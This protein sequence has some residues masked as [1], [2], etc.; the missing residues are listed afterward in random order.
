MSDEFNPRANVRK[1]PGRGGNAEYLD[2][3]DRIAWFRHDWPEGQIDTTHITLTDQIAVFRCMAVK[4]TDGGEAHGF[5]TGHGSETPGDFKDYIEKAETKAIGRALAALGYGT[6]FLPD[7][8]ERIADAPIEFAS[9]RG[10]RLANQDNGLA[11]RASDGQTVTG[12][13]LK[14]IRVIAREAG[15]D[16][17]AVRADVLESFG[18]AVEELGRQE[19]SEYIERLQA[20]SHNSQVADDAPTTRSEPPQRTE[21][22][23][24]TESPEMDLGDAIL[25]GFFTSIEHAKTEKQLDAIGTEIK[26]SRLTP[27]EREQL[28]DPFARKLAAFQAT[29]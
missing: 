24:E 6:Q 14:F 15:L 27:A 18:C 11:P 28:R 9:T 7:D 22:P 13:Q 23:D 17:A 29:S 25:A 4:I 8:G 12:R 1:L 10:R 2:V 21:P 26:R 16:D 3:K 5:A 20:L 19:A